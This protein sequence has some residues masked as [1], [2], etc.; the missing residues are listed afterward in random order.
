MDLVNKTRYSA[1]LATTIIGK[2]LMMASLI[3]KTC[4]SVENG[5]LKPLAEQRWPIGQAVETEFGNFDE[6]S[7]FRKQGIDVIVLG[8]A[9]PGEN[10]PANRASFE[11]QVGNLHYAMD[12]FGD[13][14]WVRHGD[15]LLA[16]EAEPFES[17]PLT[18]ENAYGGKCPVETGDMPYHYN[19]VGRGFYLSAETAENG[20]LPNIEDL[21]N[22]V[23]SWQ[24][25]PEP[26]GVAPLSRDSS[27]RIMNSAEFDN[28]A[29]PPELKLI[30]PS[31]Y[32]NANPELI[33]AEPPPAG[34][35][36]RAVGARPRGGDFA[37]R[38]P[39]GT[40]HMYLQLADRS[41]VFPAH[42]ETIVLLTE[43]EQV[44][45]GFRCCFRYPLK[46]LERRVAVLYGGP[47]PASIPKE[48]IIDWSRFD[49]SAVVDA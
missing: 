17:I 6:D 32:N 4:F 13:R 46:P 27:L 29:S 9:Y 5:K 11:L 39:N 12:I 14:R 21:E 34:T 47:A 16:S 23:S 40:F 25:Q 41:F 42:L 7:P 2:D 20:L 49:E 37:F 45:L 24:D 19:P 48:Y 44:M 38:L 26:R 1:A 3:V 33:L 8:K 43:L 31:Y 36:V 15:Q 18:W 28:D 30:K 35:L 10:G 22:P